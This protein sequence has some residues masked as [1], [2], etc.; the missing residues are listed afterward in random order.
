MKI[1]LDSASFAFRG[2]VLLKNLTLNLEDESYHINGPMASGKSTLLRALALKIPL[3]AGDRKIIHKGHELSNGSYIKLIQFVEVAESLTMVSNK[4]GFY[5]QRYHAG[6]EG[7]NPIL[8][9]YLT[10]FGWNKSNAY[11][12]NLILKLGLSSILDRHL[13]HLSSGQLMKMLISKSLLNQPKILF[14]DNPFAGL[15]AASCKEL[16]DIMSVLY[17]D[18]N[19]QLL[20]TGRAS[21]I[22]EFINHEISMEGNAIK[23][24][25]NRSHRLEPATEI[26]ESIANQ[27]IDYNNE[28]RNALK[29]GN[30]LEFKNVNVQYLSKPILKNISF[31]LT[32]GEKIALLGENGSGKS[33]VFSLIYGDHPLA[34]ANE[35]YLFGKRRGSGESIW[36]LKKNMGCVSPELRMNIVGYRIVNEILL[37]GFFDSYHPNKKITESDTDFVDLLLSYFDIQNLKLRSFGSL[38]SGEQQLIIF[39]RSLVQHPPLLLLDEPYQNIDWPSILKCNFLLKTLGHQNDISLMF[40]SHCQEEIPDIVNKYYEIKNGML[41]NSTESTKK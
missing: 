8:F 23:W 28:K 18:L 37:S 31:T 30:I 24:M 1:L 35:I 20:I 13:L 32:Y 12:N 3:I 14:L 25:G 33:T 19:I 40:I 10:S 6:M 9:Q 2:S 41:M 5:Q 29:K 4:N 7:Q 17:H 11:H 22:P 39:I 38:S 26:N 21:N 34:Y 15:D 16:H 36:W 27:I